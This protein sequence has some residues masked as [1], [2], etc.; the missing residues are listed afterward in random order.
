MEKMPEY[1]QAIQ[2][3]QALVANH[4]KL[5]ESLLLSKQAN[6]NNIYTDETTNGIANVPFNAGEG[7]GSTGDGTPA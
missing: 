1:I 7:I 6:D 4:N 3:G 5:L 2:E